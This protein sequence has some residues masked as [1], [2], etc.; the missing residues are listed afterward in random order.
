[1]STLDQVEDVTIHPRV[2]FCFFLKHFLLS[3]LK[4]RAQIQTNLPQ[5]SN[6]LDEL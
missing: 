4:M 5:I 3:C 1:M 6:S 2:N